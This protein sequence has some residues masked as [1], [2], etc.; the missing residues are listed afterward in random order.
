MCK[1]RS[2]AEEPA[3]Q[4]ASFYMPELE[5]SSLPDESDVR[6][7]LCNFSVRACF[8]ASNRIS[9]KKKRKFCQW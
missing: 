7:K 9:S 8:S 5:G 4:Q 6:W 2:R 3:V 1:I